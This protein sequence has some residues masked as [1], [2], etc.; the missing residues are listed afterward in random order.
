MINEEFKDK[1]LGVIQQLESLIEHR[2]LCCWSLEDQA[3]ID[4]IEVGVIALEALID[5]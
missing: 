4:G 1:I 5:D 3:Y 2:E